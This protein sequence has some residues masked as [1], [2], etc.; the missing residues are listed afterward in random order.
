MSGAPSMMPSLI[1]DF[2]GLL[3]DTESTALQAW[4]EH[5]AVHDLVFPLEV[6]HRFI[7]SQGSQQAMLDAMR[8]G[9]LEFVDA[10]L[11]AQWRSRHN[12]IVDIEMLRPGV[13]AFLD[14]ATAVGAPMAIA[15]SATRDWLEHHLSRLG[16]RD[17][18]QAVCARDSGRVKPAPDIYLAA[19]A[20]TGGDAANAVAFEDSPNGIRAAKAAGLYC[21]AVPNPVTAELPLDEADLRV[22]SFA[23]LSVSDLVRRLPGGPGYAP[24]NFHA[25]AP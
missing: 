14:E 23:E 6:W 9:G 16:I 2:D 15:S 5:F 25:P 19:L 4:R 24:P 8:T 13:E 20:A 21:V 7:G 18:F 22:E 12:G 3:V 17:R 11:L 1:F 10:D